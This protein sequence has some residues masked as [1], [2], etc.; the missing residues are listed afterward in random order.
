MSVPDY[1]MVQR[2]VRPIGITILSI[3]HGLGGVVLVI[4]TLTLLNAV[5]DDERFEK[6]LAQ[7]GIPAPLLV[8]GILYLA[9]LATAS[10]VG[11]WMGAK[12]GW[13]L[14]AFYYVYSIV[15]NTAAIIQVNGLYDAFAME[16][17]AQMT[18]GAG[19]Y[20]AK[21]GVRAFISVLIYLY[22]YKQ[23]VRAYFGLEHHRKW[24]AIAIHLFLCIDI[25]LAVTAWSK[26]SQ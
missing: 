20:Y 3:L 12:W 24:P 7:I 21:F 19:Y 18:H 14:G 2:F 9:V 4:V 1:M 16:P 8:A 13:H 5:G 26:F 23:N 11:M 15:R 10:A 6:M 25:M 22:F 17:S